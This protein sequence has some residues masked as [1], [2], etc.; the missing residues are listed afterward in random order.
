M[1]TALITGSTRGIGMQIGLD[2]LAKGYF[3]YFNGRSY[4]RFIESADINTQKHS[5]I[6][7]DLSRMEEI[8][9]INDTITKLDVLVL[10][11]GITDR[12]EFG[13]VSL[14]NWNNVFNANLTIPFFLIQE[15]RDKINKNGRI[16]FISSVLGTTPHS[17]SISYGV[18]KAGINMLA[19]Y[20]AKEFAE[21][22]ITVN[23]VVPGF[24]VTDW[25]KGKSEEQIKRI[26]DKTLLKRFGT[27][28]EV[29]KAVLSIIDNPYIT[30]QLM[31]VDGGYGLL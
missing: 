23:A 10:N 7:A 1:K 25:H 12:S 16:I 31:K 9:K 27:T 26:E 6:Q 3:V 18:S 24:V 11:I 8:K 13:N 21:R 5:F 14:D 2:L 15:L 30:G 29:S 28:E 20:L 17:R 19:Q 22:N 4:Y